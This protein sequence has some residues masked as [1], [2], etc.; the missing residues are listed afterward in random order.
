MK[1]TLDQIVQEHEI[2]FIDASLLIPDPSILSYVYHKRPLQLKQEPLKRAIEY[3]EHIYSA[4]GNFV[5]T[6][7]VAQEVRKGI[8]KLEGWLSFHLKKKSYKKAR[9]EL[10]LLRRAIN[11]QRKILEKVRKVKLKGE[12]K[13]F[14]EKISYISRENELEVS[15]QD[16]GLIA[17]AFYEAKQMNVAIVS[18]DRHFE[19]LVK[20]AYPLLAESCK[21]LTVYLGKESYVKVFETT[22]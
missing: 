10:A 11:L 18:N 2:I 17:A 13:E 14:A 8:E 20:R 9:Q 19:L 7:G 1:Y 16:I 21:A 12:I 4:P 6:R 22:L 5:L 15:E 3:L